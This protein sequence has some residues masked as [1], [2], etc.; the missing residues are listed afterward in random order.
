MHARIYPLLLA[1]CA[2]REAQKLTGNARRSGQTEV[3]NN[4]DDTGMP[5]LRSYLHDITGRQQ[6][7]SAKR[8]ATALTG[9]FSSI[10][11]YLR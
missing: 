1:T 7:A 11:T 2:A 5:G 9:Y 3:F 4:L 8:M 10:C 6:T